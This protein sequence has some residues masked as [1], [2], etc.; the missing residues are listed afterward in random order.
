MPTSKLQGVAKEE[1]ETKAVH[2]PKSERSYPAVLQLRSDYIFEG[3]IHN[4]E[5]YQSFD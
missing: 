4:R 3:H 5:R 2:Q 1:G